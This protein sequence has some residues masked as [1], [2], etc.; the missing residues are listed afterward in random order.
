MSNGQWNSCPMTPGDRLERGIDSASGRHAVQAMRAQ[1]REGAEEVARSI[2]QVVTCEC[3]C[4]VAMS[5]ERSMDAEDACPGRLVRQ[6]G[7][8]IGST[9][10]IRCGRT[11]LDQRCSAE[12]STVGP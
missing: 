1:R 9:P 4:A 10:P 5:S 2:L 11:S 3:A 8:A 12:H 6:E 7:T